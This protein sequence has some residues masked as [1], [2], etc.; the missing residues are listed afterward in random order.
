MAGRIRASVAALALA[1]ASV[2][3]G[4]ATAGDAAAVDTGRGRPGFC[5]DGDGVTVVV[6]FQGL[7]GSTIV[8]CAPGSQST[9]LTA[10]KNAGFRIAGTLRWGEGFVCRIESKPEPRRESCADTP[11]ASAYWSYWHAP[12]DGRWTYSQWGVANRTPPPGSFEGWSF[13]LDQEAGGAPAPRVAPRRPGTPAPP[14]G[15]PRPPQRQPQPQPGGGD[16]GRPAGGGGGGVGAPGGSGPGGSGPGK[17]GPGDGA[18]ANGGPGG[19]RSSGTSGSVGGGGSAAGSGGSGDRRDPGSSRP[20]APGSGPTG[21]AAPAP[22]GPATPG[23]ADERTPGPQDTP[24]EA[25]DWTGGEDDG[26]RTS[27]DSTRTVAHGSDGGGGVPVGTI[28]VAAAAAGLAGS[29][30][31]TAWRRKRAAR[32]DSAS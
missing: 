5:P 25:A 9:G 10:L 24:T 20:S 6:D 13:S 2:A 27:A 29:A 16:S 3:S 8:R 23:T 17:G 21:P 12:N 32:G 18:P 15:E 31:V 30:S 7:G 28:L 4:L 1:A 22:S 26:K 11:P 14:Q 19:G